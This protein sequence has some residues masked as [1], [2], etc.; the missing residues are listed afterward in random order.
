MKAAIQGAGA[1]ASFEMEAGLIKEI[2]QAETLLMNKLNHLGAE[3][4]E[5]WLIA[6]IY[7]LCLPGELSIS[8]ISL[9]GDAGNESESPNRSSGEMKVA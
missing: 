8:I 6:L 7:C 1:F 5:I 4:V 3:K 9:K 2:K